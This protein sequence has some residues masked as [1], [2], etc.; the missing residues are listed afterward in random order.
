MTRSLSN[1]G[2]CTSVTCNLWVFILTRLDTALQNIECLTNLLVYILRLTWHDDRISF[3]GQALICFD[4]FLTHYEFCSEHSMLLSQC[5]INL[6]QGFSLS[7]SLY[8]DGLCFALSNEYLRLAISISDIVPGDHLT[9]RLQNIGSLLPLAVRLPHHGLVNGW[10][11]FNILNLIANGVHAPFLGLML[12]CLHD[13]LVQILPLKEQR[14]KR[15]LANL[16]PHRRLGQIDDCILIRI[17]I[18][19]YFIRVKY[20]NVEHSVNMH[21]HIVFGHGLLTGNVDGLLPQIV[22]KTDRVNKWNHDTKARLHLL[23]KLHESMHHH[24]ILFRHNHKKHVIPIRLA[25]SLR[26]VITSVGKH[27]K[28]SLLTLHNRC[29]WTLCPGK[30]HLTGTESIWS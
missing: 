18:V 30:C 19:G 13:S 22:N 14:I 23:V 25:L 1:C 21:T 15:Q 2:L 4:V 5:L 24:C 16:R 8:N 28:V 7:L 3:L 20:L 29:Y 9:L 6:L 10:R 26:R 17:K 12:N 11:H 27:T